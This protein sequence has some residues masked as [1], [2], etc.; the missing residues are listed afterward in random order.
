MLCRYGPIV[1]DGDP[2]PGVSPAQVVSQLTHRVFGPLHLNRVRV[3]LD[4]HG[5]A[6]A[7]ASTLI[8]VAARH[9]V[10]ARTVSLYVKA[11]RTAGAALP[12][13]PVL[14]A[15]ATRRSTLT[16]DHLRRVRIARTLALDA[17]PART[18]PPA[19]RTTASAYAQ[20]RAASRILAA[21]GPLDTRTLLDAVGRSR[22]FRGRKPFSATDLESAL[23][24]TGALLASDGRW[25]AP[26]WVDVP[27]RYLAIARA[28]G[29]DLTRADMIQVLTDVGYSHASANG[30]M[31]SSHPLFRRVGSN[32]YRVIGTDTGK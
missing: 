21:A 31:S 17:T 13:T 9:S 5:L 15:E 1:R 14:I 4:Y 6:D 19:D 10:T 2:L 22:R 30:R 32:R 29:N 25:H 26:T 8:V 12:L 16:E 11:V 24:R 27:D 23:Q 18:Q 28:A 7:S 3:V 20:A